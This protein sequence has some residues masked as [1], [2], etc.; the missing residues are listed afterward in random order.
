MQLP[1][2]CLAS[3]TRCNYLRRRAADLS[4]RAAVSHAKASWRLFVKGNAKSFESSEKIM[5][6]AKSHWAW[7]GLSL[8]ISAMQE[9]VVA[10]LAGYRG[11]GRQA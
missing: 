8:L 6:L 9:S 2:H 4:E 10:Q 1:G 7:S 5:N 11:C 3:R